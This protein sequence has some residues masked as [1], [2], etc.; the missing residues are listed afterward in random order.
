MDEEE[1]WGD[2]VVDLGVDLGVVEDHCIP[3]E[4]APSQENLILII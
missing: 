1:D 2:E 4:E 3:A